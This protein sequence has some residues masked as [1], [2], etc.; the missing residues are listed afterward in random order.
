MPCSNCGPGTTG[1]G[2][3]VGGGQAPVKFF[4]VAFGDGKFLHVEAVPNLADQIQSIG[5]AK[6]IDSQIV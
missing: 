4:A 3:G 1:G 2:I 6:G 5:G